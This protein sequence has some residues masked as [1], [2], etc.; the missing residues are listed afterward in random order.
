M[1]GE[2]LELGQLAQFV[3]LAQRRDLSTAV[4]RP[5]LSS[6]L[7]PPPNP[8]PNPYTACAHAA[9]SA[10][11]STVLRRG[12]ALRWLP[13][14]RGERRLRRHHPACVR[15]LGVVGCGVCVDGEPSGR[16]AD[17]QAACTHASAH[18]VKKNHGL[19]VHSLRTKTTNDRFMS[20]VPCSLRFITGSRSARIRGRGGGGGGGRHGR[21]PIR[22]RD[23]RAY[24]R[25]AADGMRGRDRVTGGA[26]PFVHGRPVQCAF[27]ARTWLPC[28]YSIMRLV[29]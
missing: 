5:T 11:V 2:L 23:D 1:E 16:H 4:A 9:S 13:P 3:D 18:L 20:C 29:N 21:T 8:S 26:S 15:V 7:P 25:D 24:W 17:G 12:L 14:L 10:S 19:H 27:S 6:T 22:W 28:M